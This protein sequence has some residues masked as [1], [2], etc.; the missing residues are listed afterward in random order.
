[1]VH[2]Y[3]LKG[4]LTQEK[5]VKYNSDPLIQNPRNAFDD[6]E[7]T[8]E[9]NSEGEGEQEQSKSLEM[10]VVEEEQEEV[11]VQDTKKRPFV[12]VSSLQ[13]TFVKRG[14]V[15]ALPSPQVDNAKRPKKE[16]KKISCC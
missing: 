9:A 15:L 8:T 12:E 11:H 3:R 16:L 10:I 1:M 2:L 6:L 14:S 4:W 5:A 7:F 13:M